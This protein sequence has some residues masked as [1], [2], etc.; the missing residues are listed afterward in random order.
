MHRL[1]DRPQGLPR[2]ELLGY[3]ANLAQAVDYLNEPQHP[4]ADGTLVGVQH[5]EIKPH[6]VFL[7]GG[8][9]RLADFGVAKVLSVSAA[10]HTGAMSPTDASPEAMEGRVS[11][12]SDQNSLAV[13]YVQLRTG[14]VL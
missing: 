6:N 9:V 3:M 10:S 13:T 14:R 7:V 5:R 8:L 2:G 1:R 11:S 12:R 4:S